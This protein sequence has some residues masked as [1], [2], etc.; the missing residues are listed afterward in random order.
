MEI[1]QDYLLPCGR[2]VETMWERLDEP[3]E[4][5]T[6]CEHCGGARA[7]LLVLRELTGELIADEP[8]PSLDLTGRIMAAVRADVRKRD[9][10][11]VATT[12]PGAVRVSA[13]AVAAVLRFAAD[14]V[15][16]VRARRCKVT[17]AADYS[18]IVEMTIAVAYREFS[19]TALALVRD[20]VAAAASARVGVRL[21]RLD[22]TMDDLYES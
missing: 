10:L 14:S 21:A 15:E 20:R 11:P 6:G 17:E 18:V 8:E 4:H 13:Q 1:A 12:E 19:G 3:D 16:G 2:D 9:L 7:S 5:E 22:L